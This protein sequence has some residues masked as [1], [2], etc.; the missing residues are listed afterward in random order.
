MAQT[1]IF[2]LLVV[3][4]GSSESFTHDIISVRHVEND[5][6][7]RI[8]KNLHEFGRRRDFNEFARR[9]G[10]SLQMSSAPVV[11]AGIV[12]VTSSISAGL[13]GGSLH[14]ITG[15]DHLAALIPKCCGKRWFT[16]VRVGAVWG[17][18]H[19]ISSLILGI[20]AFA[21]KS[22]LNNI[23]KIRTLLSGASHLLE[24]AVGLSV[25]IVGLMGI[26]EAREWEEDNKNLYPVSLSSAAIDPHVTRTDTKTILFNGFLHGFSWDGA[27]SLVPALAVTTWRGNLSFLL[28][29]GLGTMGAMSIATTLVGEGTRKAGQ[30]F[31]RP[32]IPQKLSMVFSCIAVMIGV[33]WTG[34]AF[35]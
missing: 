35:R 19:G 9:R 33:T 28:A 3:L 26:R 20:S 30:I 29:Y 7:T 23:H 32:D 34:L 4:L 14:A 27:P 13:V 8:P 12:A 21:L 16:A 10:S 2:S 18:G 31:N 5:V 22:H 15:P 25:L 1:S 17:I 24:V 11:S 6:S